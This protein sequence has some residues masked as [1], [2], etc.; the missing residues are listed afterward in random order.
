VASLYDPKEFPEFANIFFYSSYDY[1]SIQMPVL[2]RQ[3]RDSFSV[4]PGYIVIETIKKIFLI[5]LARI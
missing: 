3:M 1:Y 5:V 2:L 4:L